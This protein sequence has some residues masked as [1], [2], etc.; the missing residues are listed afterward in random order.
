MGVFIL[1]KKL[2]EVPLPL[3][4][5]N[6]A[7]VDEKQKTVRLAHPARLHLWWARRPLT[8]SR[9]VL[10]AQLVDDPGPG[11][12]RDRLFDILRSLVKPEGPSKEV[13]EKAKAAIRQSV[14]DG[15]TVLDPFAGGGAIPIEAQRLGL[16]VE[17]SDLNPVAVLLNRLVLEQVSIAMDR[18]PVRPADGV[19]AG[20]P[21]A[22]T[23]LTGTT[24][25]NTPSAGI[26]ATGLRGLEEDICWYGERLRS[27]AAEVLVDHYPDCVD[28]AG[29][30][31][32]VIAWLWARTAPCPNPV[33]Q[34][35]APLVR[36]FVLS[37]KKG[38]EAWVDP[39]TQGP[40]H[41]VEFVVRTGQTPRVKGT[42]GRSVATCVAC[43]TAIPLS[44]ICEQGRN[45]QIRE[46]LMAIVALGDRRRLYI[47]PNNEHGEAACLDSS[48]PLGTEFPMQVL[49]FNVQKYGY[50]THASLFTNRQL[51]VLNTLVLQLPLIHEEVLKAS[52]GED[53]AYA[54]L[55]ATVLGIS[56]SKLANISNSFCGWHSTNE[57]PVKMIARQAPKMVWDFAEANVLGKSSGS[58]HKTVKTVARSLTGALATYERR[59]IV[60]VGQT[61]AATREYPSDVVICMDPP[62][63]DSTEYANLSDFFYIWLR[64]GLKDFH[65]DLFA[66]L[67]TPKAEEFVT[68][69]YRFEGVQEKANEHCEEGFRQVCANILPRHHPDIPMTIFYTNE[70]KDSETG[71]KAGGSGGGVTG[72]EKLLQGLVDTGLQVTATWPIRTDASAS[73]VVLVCR[74]RS[75]DAG[76]TDRQG[77]VRRLRCEL[78]SE[79]DKLHASGIQP[80][81]MA[82]ASIGPGMAVFTS[83]ARVMEAGEQ[84]MSVGTALQVINQ[85][86]DELQ[87]EQEG[88]LDPCTR[89]AML[90]FEQFGMQ[91][92]DLGD[93][94]SIATARGTVMNTIKQL[95]IVKSQGDRVRLRKSDEYPA[96]W[97]PST[98]EAP[99]IWGVCQH[100]IRCLDGDGGVSDAA[101]LLRQVDGLA[102]AVRDLSYR[103]YEISNR[104]GWDN[105]AHSYNN[106]AA[107]WPGL[108]VAA[109]QSPLGQMTLL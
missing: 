7:T 65:P 67:L 104:C 99:P 103:L 23:P 18:P 101:E 82:Q 71:S 94:Q 33:C 12:E 36:S 31:R 20:T 83:Y 6:D 14:G 66:T 73:S 102:D 68:T 100:I 49:G 64:L 96:G 85:V 51:Y 19:L 91:T 13:V 84:S 26:P 53:R 56:I 55:V 28:D 41:N 105:E 92:A 22:G 37:K 46:R 75:E 60:T 27:R 76:V 70:H 86:L 108:V 69:P 5:I 106:L 72:W 109:A 21:L 24:T 30:P 57:V 17:A 2:I 89:W 45:G 3:T 11:A 78:K 16:Q 40:G 44:S 77:F 48:D 93:A 34:I 50:T 32:P 90:W 47:S 80:L 59:E 39:V 52:G 95:G 63:F 58:L 29:K 15:V 9:A 35:D 74:Q 10:F 54:D 61:N 97:V 87:S 98:D 42:V 62:Y 107:E 81:D 88:E 25:S 8:V 43:Q 4:E 79:L 1:P 38:R